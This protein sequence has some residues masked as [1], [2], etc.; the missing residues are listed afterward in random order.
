MKIRQIHLRAILIAVSILFLA[1]FLA[2]AENSKDIELLDRSARAFS[3]VVKD[4]KPAV[5]HIAVTSTVE[6]NSE[7]EQFFNH[8]FFEK[9][10]GPEYRFQDPQRRK[11]QQ[12]GAGSGFIIDREG[13]ILT[14]NHVV[15]KA[16]KITVT[17]NDNSEVEA[18][19][20]GTDPKSDV[21][22]IKID[23]DHDLPV[24]ELGD[25]SALEV[26]EWVIAIGNPFGLSQTVTVGVVSAT[27]RSRV[28]INE[29]ENFIQTD[30]AINPGNSGGPLLNIHG[31]VVGINSALYSRTGGY[32]GIGFAIP[33]NM[34][35]FIN[36][37]LMDNGKVTRGY[38]GVGIQDVDEA[39]AESFGLEKAGGVLITDVQDDTPAS[40]AGVKSQDVLVKLD[41]IDLQDT[42][43]LRNRIAQTIPG[44]TVVLDIVRDGKP[45]ELKVKIGEQPADFGI[46][47]QGSS[48]QNPLSPF[49][50]VVQ[51]L[52][53]D[54]AE[55]LGYKGRQ[56]LVISEVE[57]GSAAAE[58]GLKS[59]FLIE[60][61]QKVRVTSLEELRQVMEQSGA[62]ERVLLRVR[63]GQNSRYVV[64][65]NN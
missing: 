33:I 16:D 60:E 19:L 29:Y 62:S 50:L 30:A 42:Q 38:L 31:Q 52:T 4:V 47:A 23:V 12:Q 61:V 49:G 57:P 18:T 24:V 41:G 45:V 17:L 1:P 27:G 44:T 65:K 25:S 59:G 11:R 8:P 39:L 58:I 22:L 7:Y 21:A 40:K 53:A 35:K 54:L 63:V 48:D 32:M 10:F 64:L 37:Q 9:F 26:G 6:T 46:A 34:A 5:V 20:I 56:G 28:G 43:D 51:E 55:Q 36:E 2:R 15:E 14:N 13:H 3:R